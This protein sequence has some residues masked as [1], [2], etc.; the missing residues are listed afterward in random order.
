L[1]QKNRRLVA[2]LALCTAGPASTLAAERLVLI[3]RLLRAPL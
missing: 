2:R 3:S 1:R